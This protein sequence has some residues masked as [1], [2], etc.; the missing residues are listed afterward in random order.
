MILGRSQRVRATRARARVSRDVIYVGRI[1]WPEIVKP[2]FNKLENSYRPKQKVKVKAKMGTN[3]NKPNGPDMHIR[4]NP[5][6]RGTRGCT[7]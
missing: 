6:V 5:R 4:G 2:P 1:I 3:K 7:T